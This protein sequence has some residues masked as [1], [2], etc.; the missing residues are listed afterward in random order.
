MKLEALKVQ[1]QESPCVLF[2]GGSSLLYIKLGSN[3]D[4]KDRVKL[5]HF[6]LGGKKRLWKQ[7]KNELKEM[8]LEWNVWL[9]RYYSILLSWGTWHKA[10]LIGLERKYALKKYTGDGLEKCGEDCMCRKI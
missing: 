9:E 4:F 8:N 5:F 1:D 2:Y 7:R 3:R 10:G 6:Y